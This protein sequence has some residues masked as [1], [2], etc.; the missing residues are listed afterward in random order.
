MTRLESVEKTLYGDN[1]KKRLNS[2]VVS[3]ASA[4]AI[5][6][7]KKNEHPFAESMTVTLGGGNLLKIMQTVSFFQDEFCKKP[8]VEFNPEGFRISFARKW[9]EIDS[10]IKG[11]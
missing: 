11:S 6:T 7:Y 4:I 5:L 9:A 2:V 1:L 10:E 3:F 8:F